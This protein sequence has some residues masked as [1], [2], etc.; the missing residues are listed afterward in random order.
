[1]RTQAGIFMSTSNIYAKPPLSLEDQLELLIGRGLNVS[2]PERA[3]HYLRFVGYYR[4]SGYCRYYQQNLSHEFES[5]TTF[6]SVLKLYIFDRELRLLVMDAVER[7][8]VAVRSCIS[9]TMSESHGAHWFMDRTLFHNSRKHDELLGKIR[10]ATGNHDRQEGF[11]KSYYQKYNQPDIP[12]SWMMAEVMSFGTWSSLFANLKSRQ[13]QR[14][15]CAP[16]DID[17]RIMKSWLH[18]LNYLRNL[19][20]HHSRLWNRLFSIKP[21][22]AKKYETQMKDNGSFYA[23][24]AMLRILMYVIADGSKWQYRFADLVDSYLDVPFSEMGFPEGW[25]K[26]PFWGLDRPDRYSF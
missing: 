11:L 16:F 7:I 12:P 25:R 15:I 17:P 8:E 22:V 26:D 5:G 24:A 19:C 10:A 23:Y 6:D 13:V 2:S 18:S 20:A 1:M 14:S 4:L 3:L 9:N 21:M